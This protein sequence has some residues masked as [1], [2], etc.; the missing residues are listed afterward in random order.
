MQNLLHEDNFESDEILLVDRIYAKAFER[1]KCYTQTVLVY[2]ACRI[3]IIPSLYLLSR[4][5]EE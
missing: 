3:A 5:V 2:S 4:N 1:F